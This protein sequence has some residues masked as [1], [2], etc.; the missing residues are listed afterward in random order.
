MKQS[1]ALDILKMGRNVFLTGPAGSGKTFVLNKYINYLKQKRAGVGVTASTGIAATHLGGITIHSWSGLGIKE[2]ISEKDLRKILKKSYLK[3]RFKNTG[4][5]VIDEISMINAGQLDCINKICQV[6]KN[7]ARPFGGIQ[8]VFSGDFFQL[9]PIRKNGNEQFVSASEIWNEMDIKICYLEEQHRQE[10]GGLLSLLNNIRNSKVKE[11]KEILNSFDFAKINFSIMPTKLYTHNVDVDVVN[12]F[13]LEKINEDGRVYEMKYSGNKN[14][15]EALKK[16]CLAPEKLVLKKGAKVM[17]VKNN[18]E[19]GY[20]NGTLGE[21]VYFDDADE[22]P[23][24]KIYNG[25]LIKA[26]PATWIIEED[27]TIKA[28][29]NQIPLRLAW[30]ITVHKSQ[31]MN[32]DAAEI[33]L[34]K[35]FVE[36]MGYVALSRLRAIEGLKVNG[37]NEMAFMV[38]REIVEL[39]KILKQMSDTAVKEVRGIDCSTKEKTQEQFLDSLPRVEKREDYFKEDKH[40][41]STHEITELLV[42]QKKS[43]EEISSVRNLTQETIIDHLE[44]IKNK[45]DLE[46]LKPE[47]KRFEKIKKA[48]LKTGDLKLSPVKDMLGDSFSYLEIRLARLF[49]KKTSGE[50]K[51]V[52]GKFKCEICGREIKHRGNCLPCNVKAKKLKEKTI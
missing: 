24:V 26:E 30:G 22:L 33:D 50:Q 15:A 14:I 25:R 42:V 19:S 20:V 44:K 23:V 17:F 47:K 27:D 16:G 18:F 3:N 4:V 41:I 35:C 6:F 38:N 1:E 32:L 36:G 49:I 43:I 29:I 11:A 45:T 5:L 9:P 2:N 10:A 40:I 34:S 46:Y 51:T 31:G 39:D 52:A 21:V 13:E 8:L 12:N 37:I 28:Q 7:S 48:F